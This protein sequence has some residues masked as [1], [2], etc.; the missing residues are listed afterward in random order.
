MNP[1]VDQASQTELQQIEEAV[2]ALDNGIGKKRQEI[3]DRFESEINRLRELQGCE[4][5]KLDQER[6]RILLELPDIDQ[7]IKDHPSEAELYRRQLVA[8]LI[9]TGNWSNTK[10]WKGFDPGWYLHIIQK[11][12]PTTT[13]FY[14]G[15]GVP[16]TLP[17]KHGFVSR[18]YCMQG[19]TGP[20]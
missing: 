19:Y 12:W 7:F 15:Q 8:D 9:A 11:R 2:T 6:R 3:Y 20:N 5:V 18:K 16:K 17:L 10:T 1:L 13:L 14:S 4:L